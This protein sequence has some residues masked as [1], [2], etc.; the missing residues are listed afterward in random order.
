MSY[1]TALHILYLKTPMGD[2]AIEG[3]DIGVTAIQFLEE[4][5]TEK[6]SPQLPDFLQDAAI[7]LQEYFDK[8]RTEFDFPLDLQGTDFQKRVWAELLNIPYGKT[9]S[10]L[11]VSLALGDRKAIRAVGTANGRN[12]VAIVVPCHRVIGSDGSLVGY[13][14][15]LAR[16]KWL[17]ELEQPFKQGSLF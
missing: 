6:S 17:L 7:Q 3:S 12:P 8:K 4:E 15:G 5:P 9:V 16:K 1:K 13:A 10:Y 2:I 11:H 14:S